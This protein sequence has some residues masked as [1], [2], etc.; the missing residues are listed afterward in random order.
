MID[1]Y[2]W[3]T[4]NGKKCTIML[5]ECGL[6]YNTIAVDISAGAQFEPDFLA[7]SPNNKIPVLVDPDG[8]GG[9]AISVNDSVA[10]LLYLAEK[11]GRFWVSDARERHT[12]MPWLLFQAAHIGPMLGQNHHFRA[13]APEKLPYAIDRYTTEASRLYGVL[14]TRLEQNEWIGGG[15]YT[16]L[17]MATFPWIVPHERQGQ[18][19]GDFPALERWFRACESRPAV[20]RGMAVLTDLKVNPS[21]DKA[22]WQTLFGNKKPN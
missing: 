13:Y 11:T 10:I 17:D 20:Q 7:M 2:Y 21:M 3:A 8:P 14:N 19:L 6:E 18:D 5:E 12:L 4:P 1:L 22:A 15:E 16:I 9:E